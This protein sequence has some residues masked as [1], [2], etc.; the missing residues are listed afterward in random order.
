MLVL[1]P[2]KP[3]HPISLELVPHP[4]V[5]P[6]S[7]AGEVALLK[8]VVVFFGDVTDTRNTHTSPC[9]DLP[10]G[11]RESS[12]DGSCLASHQV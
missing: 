3:Q 6:V 11:T 7:T 4:E 8:Q 1:D 2:P 5:G 10:E 12:R 9:L